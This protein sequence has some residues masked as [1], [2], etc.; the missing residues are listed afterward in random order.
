MRWVKCISFQT[1]ESVKAAA[2]SQRNSMG[3]CI[4][5]TGKEKEKKKKNPNKPPCILISRQ[6]QSDVQHQPTHMLYKVCIKAL[7]RE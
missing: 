7:R 1:E 2:V 5:P 6:Q 4:S 3:V